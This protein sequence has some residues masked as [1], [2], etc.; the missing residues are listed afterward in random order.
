M[1]KTTNKLIS[2]DG[3]LNTNV[4]INKWEFK[5]ADTSQNVYV[6]SI[7]GST[8]IFTNTAGSAT[9]EIKQEDTGY[10]KVVYK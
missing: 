3:G 5:D 9:V 7:T 2:N 10:R 4:V 6:E 8:V 1:D